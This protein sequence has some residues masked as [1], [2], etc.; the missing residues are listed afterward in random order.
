VSNAGYVGILSIELHF[1]D[2]GSLKGKRK[3]VKSAKA[4]LQQR[5]GAAVAEVDHH[6][7]WQRSR[8]VLTCAAREMG[9]LHGLLD[10]ADRWLHGQDWVVTGVDR[11]IVSL[12]D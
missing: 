6:D 5:F 2:A 10:D 9:E 7:L 4:Q 11:R 1:P 3:Y 12:E 8:L